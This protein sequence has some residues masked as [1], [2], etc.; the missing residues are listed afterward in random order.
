MMALPGSMIYGMIA[1]APLGPAYVSH[2]ILAGLYS[3]VFAGFFVAVA[4]GTQGMIASPRAPT[5]IVFAAVIG[6]FMATGVVN[7]ESATALA[8]VLALGLFMVFL[9]GAIQVAFGALR[10]AGV[11]KYI[12]YPV[13]AGLLDGTV[14]V[15]LEK[16]FWRCLGIEPQP[17]ITLLGNLGQIK[18][19]MLLIALTSIL[20]WVKGGKYIRHVPGA[21]LG[22][23]GGTILYYGLQTLGFETGI[24]GTLVSVSV[25]Y[26]TPR[27]LFRFMDTLVTVTSPQIW[28][29]ILSGALTIAILGSMDSLLAVLTMQNLTRV[30]ADS[31]Q[32]LIGQGIGNMVNAVFGAVPAGGAVSRVTV[33]YNAGGRSRLSGVCFSVC[34]LLVVLLGAPYIRFLPQAAAAGMTVVVGLTVLDKW[35]IQL[36]KQALQ[37]NLSDRR[38][39]LLN[40]AKWLYG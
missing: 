35:S 26:P 3:S 17:V 21:V 12:S 8:T 14:I 15:I 19:L 4:G 16:A 32:E 31:N 33:N 2:A 6:Q 11:V 25:S 7:P 40:I 36:V 10:I 34:V 27:Y 13:V 28:P 24:G 38:T 20:L 18:P 37:K 9:S 22:L 5:M 29:M 30:R 39:L 23:L 1:F